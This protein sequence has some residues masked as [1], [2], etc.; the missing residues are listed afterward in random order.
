MIAENSEYCN[1]QPNPS[2]CAKEY[3]ETGKSCNQ[4]CFANCSFDKCPKD[5]K[6]K[7]SPVTN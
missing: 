4:A 7:D 2:L 3:I 5:K 6:V 1:K